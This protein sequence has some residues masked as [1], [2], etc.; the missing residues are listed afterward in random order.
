MF[1]KGQKWRSEIGNRSKQSR[2]GTKFQMLVEDVREGVL[3][4]F[5]LYQLFVFYMNQF[6]G[7]FY[8]STDRI[9]NFIQVGI[10]S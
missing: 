10:I 2:G 5:A 8:I 4:S 9:Y 1:S 6:T 3:V 7:I